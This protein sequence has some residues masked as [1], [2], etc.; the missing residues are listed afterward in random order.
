MDS[1][2]DPKTEPM[3]SFHMPERRLRD[4]LA[5]LNTHTVADI[6][7]IL[8]RTQAF[9]Q[10]LKE[11]PQPFS[12]TTTTVVL[13]FYG[14]CPVHQRNAF[15]WTLRAALGPK[16]LHSA[17]TKQDSFEGV[18][19]LTLREGTLR[20]HY[21]N[22]WEAPT[23]ADG[24]RGTPQKITPIDAFISEVQ[25][26][27]DLFRISTAFLDLVTWGNPSTVSALRRIEKGTHAFGNLWTNS[28]RWLLYSYQQNLRRMEDAQQNE[29]VRRETGL[30]F[31]PGNMLQ[32]YH[33]FRNLELDMARMQA[34]HAQILQHL[35]V[36]EGMV[37]AQARIWAHVIPETQT[38]GGEGGGA[39]THNDNATSSESAS[40]QPSL[41]SPVH[42]TPRY[43]LRISAPLRTPPPN[44]I[45]RPV[46]NPPPSSDMENTAAANAENRHPNL[47]T[48]W[49]LSDSFHFMQNS[50]SMFQEITHIRRLIDT[51][52]SP[53]SVVEAPEVIDLTGGV[54]RPPSPPE[55]RVPEPSFLIV[56]RILPRTTSM[57]NTGQH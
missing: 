51:T 41:E 15:L 52:S 12:Y 37:R 21:H 46:L 35:N 3:K 2:T 11:R 8:S 43:N 56:R 7:H 17:N 38:L 39:G 28:N 40:N 33:D 13:A 27:A 1:S 45:R 50:T 23:L 14:F 31:T 30:D 48:P 9:R 4:R 18:M 32:T 20:N 19:L 54:S 25:S 36:F 53:R 10:K 55:P 47:G 5:R 57:R 22:H 26:L 42:T 49:P 16:L 24:Q 44:Q 29:H 34:S 6:N